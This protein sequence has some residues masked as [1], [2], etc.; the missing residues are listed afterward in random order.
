VGQSKADWEIVCAIAK[1]MGKSGFDY[2]GVSQIWDEVAALTPSYAGISY[3]RLEQG[4]L[5]WPC[6]TTDH[7]GTSILHTAIF[8]RGKGKFIPLS[9]KPSMEVPDDKYPLLLTTERSLFQYHTG[10]MTRKVKGLNVFRGEE[11]VEINPQDAASLGIA[12][13][14]ILKV[15]SRRGE[16]TAKAKITGVTPVGVVSMSFHFA[17]SPTNVV[18][19]PYLDPIAKIPELK[20]CAVKV[21]KL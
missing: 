8:T 12:G 17:E 18:T 20:V 21:E 13:G 9:Y 1:S 10:T 6:P 11:F 4:G 14:D 15:S 2:A 19:S 7:P 16:V 5:Q 3:S